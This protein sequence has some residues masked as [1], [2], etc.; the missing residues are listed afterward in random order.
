[1]PQKLPIERQDMKADELAKELAKE[2]NIKLWDA[3][4]RVEFCID[5]LELNPEDLN[6]NQSNEIRRCIRLDIQAGR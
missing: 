6:P 3:K 2:L 1:M 5:E 4:S